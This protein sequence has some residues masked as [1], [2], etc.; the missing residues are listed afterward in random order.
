MQKT[1]DFQKAL[2]G[3]LTQIDK[4]ESQLNG[5]TSG[6]LKDLRELLAGLKKAWQRVETF[7][8]VV[9][10]EIVQKVSKQASALDDRLHALQRRNLI[11][12]SGVIIVAIAVLSASGWWLLGSHSASRSAL[13]IKAAIAARLPKAAAKLSK[14]A[15]DSGLTRFSA[16]LVS[17]IAEAETY[18]EAEEARLQ[19]AVS[20]L[21]RFEEWAKA[22]FAG[23]DANTLGQDWTSYRESLKAIADETITPHIPRIKTLDKSIKTHIEG[24][25]GELYTSI[26]E[27]VNKFEENFL[28]LVR[29]STSLD[30][31]QDFLNR[32]QSEVRDW[33]RTLQA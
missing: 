31:L 24:K 18:A 13:E 14:D 7:S 4:A 16:S 8:M 9:A 2:R 20:G 30:Q 12:A 3:L 28:S 32:A 27:R 21:E 22:D 23:K 33:S 5:S 26:Q 6:G 10:P 25:F 17:T 29:S 19:E 15:H 11:I 1:A